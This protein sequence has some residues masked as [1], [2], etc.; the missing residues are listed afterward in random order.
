M[1]CSC[2]RPMAVPKTAASCVPRYPEGSSA[3]LPV[4][5]LVGKFV[6]VGQAVACSRRIDRSRRECQSTLGRRQKNDYPTDQ[7]KR[8]PHRSTP[9]SEM[10]CRLPGG[11]VIPVEFAWVVCAVALASWLSPEDLSREDE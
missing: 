2:C 6:R 1:G 8:S 3:G 4:R 5:H 10:N 9:H 11:F 7:N